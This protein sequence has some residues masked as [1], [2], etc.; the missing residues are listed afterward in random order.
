MSSPCNPEDP[1]RV[2]VIEDDRF[3]A[4]VLETALDRDGLAVEVVRSGETA[5]NLVKT[6][7]PPVLAF[8]DLLLPGP[9][10]YALIKLMKS[11]PGWKEV[12]VV[13]ISGLRDRE[14]VLSAVRL[15]ISGYLEKPYDLRRLKQEVEKYLA[16]IFA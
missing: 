5:W 1:C 7:E 10:G 3:Q 9:D 12:P 6:G 11:T 14:S 4:K 2:L 15:G 13:V 8:V 16:D